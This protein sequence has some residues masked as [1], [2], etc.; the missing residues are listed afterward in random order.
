[1]KLPNLLDP[2]DEMFG[3][4]LDL[5][6]GIERVMG[7]RGMFA[8]ILSR[9]RLDYGRAACAIRTALSEGDR[10]L[11][12]R[13]THT[14]KG[15][16]GLIE[17]R[18]LHLQA[19]ALENVLRAHIDHRT[20]MDR[21]ETEL[22]RVLRELDKLLKNTAA[23]VPPGSVAQ[24]AAPRRTDMLE[25]L[26][27][28]LDVGDGAAVELFEESRQQLTDVLGKQVMQELTLAMDAFD[29]ERALKL[30]GQ[31]AARPTPDLRPAYSGR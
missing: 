25:R 15:A 19:L 24:P 7:D 3:V 27:Q 1:M 14:L 9:F 10:P 13:L 22:N 29:F 16:S 6:G 23:P 5:A 2:A 26:R 31:P 11:A 4:P 8:R 12:Q 18:P 17:A 30:L 20:A 28:L 21:L